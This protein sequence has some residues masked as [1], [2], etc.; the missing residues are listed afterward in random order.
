MQK[1]LTRYVKGLT[2]IMDRLCIYVIYDAENV[3]DEYVTY[4]LK[5][6]RT[7]CTKLV[8][9]CNTGFDRSGEKIDSLADQVIYRENI[10]YDAGGYKDALCRYIGWDRLYMYDELL[11]L[12]DSFYGPIYPMQQVFDRM[13]AIET[14][15]W[16]LTRSQECLTVKDRHYKGHIQSYFMVFRK[17]VINNSIFKKF[18]EQLA[19]PE[20]MDEAIEY[21]ELG[22]NRCLE[23]EGFQSIA[24]SDFYQDMIKFKENENPYL[25]YPLELIRDCSIPILKYKSLTFG[26]EGYA[27]ALKAYQFIEENCLY[28][29][30]YIKNHFWRKSKYEEGMI[31]LEK[32]EKFYENHRRVYIYGYGV[33][34]KN[35]GLYFQ[36]RK[37]KIEGFLVTAAKEGEEA[38]P[39]E[40]AEMEREDGLVV[41]V[42][43][44]VLCGEILAYLE[45]KCE[46][47]QLMFPNY[48]LG[49]KGKRNEK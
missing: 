36:Y 41:A 21:F 6:L 18:W 33:Y 1:F 4:M 12:N 24:I 39:F 8:V 43:K 14:D 29:V 45:D 7:Y 26:N 38:V 46:R 44:K 16:G 49:F 34:G 37:W 32:L 3:I 11:L 10:G 42:G 28:D 35:F 48:G 47:D 2:E 40:E 5:Q 20:K 22:I 13:A 15:Y 19:Y 17:N 23:E 27:N 25:R 9:V 31:D 30:M